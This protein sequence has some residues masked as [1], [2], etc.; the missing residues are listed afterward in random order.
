MTVHGKSGDMLIVDDPHVQAFADLFD[1]LTLE[2]QLCVEFGFRHVVI[3]HR[4]DLMETALT[5]E[6]HAYQRTFLISDQTI[7]H[8]VLTLQQLIRIHA[9]E[10]D[11]LMATAGARRT[12]MDQVDG[13]RLA[14]LLAALP[15]H[16]R[17]DIERWITTRP[18][19]GVMARVHT[20]DFTGVIDDPRDGQRAKGAAPNKGTAPK[21]KPPVPRW[22]RDRKAKTSRPGR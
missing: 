10:L 6:R 22:A 7:E 15:W 11:V 17:R 5:V 12:P 3:E 1:K 21:T 13:G 4:D 16:Q 14:P 19:I 20:E 2:Q 9:R 18:R 8:C